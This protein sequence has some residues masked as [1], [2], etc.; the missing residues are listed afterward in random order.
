MTSPIVA[1]AL[2]LPLWL[3]PV[4]GT[5]AAAS[6]DPVITAAGDIASGGEPSEPQI[7]TAR[8][9]RSIG[10]TAALTLGDNQYP[11]GAL[12]DFESSYDPTWGRFTSITRPVPG[13]HD[14]HI[15]G[16]DGYFDYFGPRAHRSHGGY[17]S[18]D[19]GDWHLVAVNS[20][21]GAIS[22]RQLRWVRRDLRRSQAR[23]ELAY[24][25]HPRW[26]SG[27]QHGSDEDM[28]ALW[29]VLFRAGVDVVLNG[30][31]HDYERFAPLTP[32]GRRA[33]RTGI[34]EFVV[35][36]GGAGPYGFGDPIS[37]SQVRITGAYGVLEMTLHPD[38]YRWEFVRTGGKILDG[39]RHACHA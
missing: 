25:H 20:G 33:P 36:T 32:T 5:R 11:D 26:S 28:A 9:V 16:A 12:A 3:V 19:L 38:G 39:G 2:L 35:G 14:Y 31:E 15:A 23:C 29:R 7:R 13:N 27:S 6:A 18:Y 22:D 24:W 8:L 37:G 1:L 10:P 34:R 30:H 17:Y 4:S 21:T